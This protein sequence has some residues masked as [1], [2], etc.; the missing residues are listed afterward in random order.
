M[1]KQNKTWQMAKNYYEKEG[2][3]LLYDLK[4]GSYIER[5]NLIEKVVRE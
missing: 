1:F 4:I 5:V 2:S 3:E